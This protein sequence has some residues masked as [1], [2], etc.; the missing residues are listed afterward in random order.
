MTSNFLN[1]DQGQIALP[2]V[3]NTC[4][5]NSTIQ[6]LAGT[7]ELLQYFF[8]Y[9]KLDNGQHI[10]R[11][12]KHHW[13]VLAFIRKIAK[14]KEVTLIKG[15]HDIFKLGDYT[16]YFRDIRS[17]HVTNI[18]DKRKIIFSHI[19][20]HEESLG[21]FKY[22]IHGHLHGNRVLKSGIVDYRYINVCVEWTNYA[23]IPYDTVLENLTTY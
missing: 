6:C 3:G 5:L 4:Y 22:N 21:R 15:N 12:K 14:T 7:Q 1:P 19:P 17:Y 2:N 18:S 11:Y 10:K 20:L 16:P 13:K 8:Q 23:P 9:A